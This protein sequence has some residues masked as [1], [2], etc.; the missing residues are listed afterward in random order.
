MTYPLIYNGSFFQ[1]FHG[2][3]SFTFWGVL[4]LDWAG[5]GCEVLAI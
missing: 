1:W 5:V 2:N 3:V 4:E